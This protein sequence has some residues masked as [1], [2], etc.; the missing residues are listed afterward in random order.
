MSAKDI[1]GVDAEGAFRHP[2]DRVSVYIVPGKVRESDTSAGIGRNR[3]YRDGSP[4]HVLPA[5]S[6]VED[7][8]CPVGKNL[9]RNENERKNGD[10]EPAEVEGVSF[11]LVLLAEGL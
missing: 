5:G 9:C 6:I 7:L 8:G 10:K 2:Q 3:F 1:P 4:Q 11:P